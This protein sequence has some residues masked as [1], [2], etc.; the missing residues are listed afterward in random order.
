MHNQLL[1]YDFTKVRDRRTAY[2]Q[3]LGKLKT[4]RSTW[5]DHW[6]DISRHLLPR[7]GRY[8]KTDRNKTS[9]SKYNKIYDNSATRAL[10]TLGAGMMAGASNPAR[11]WFRLQTSDPELND[12]Y[13]VRLWLD[14]VV[15]RMQR[16][17]ARSNTYR[18]LHKMYEELGAFGTSVSIVLFDFD[19]VIHHYP[20]ANG[21]YSLQQNAQGRIVAVYREYQQTVGEVVKEYGLT[22]IS[23]A[24]KQAWRAR[25]LEMPIN[26]MHMI[27]PRADQ[28]RNP[29]SR[30][31]TDM[32]WKSCHLEMSSEDN[33]ILRES[34]FKHFPVLAPR[35][36]VDGD[37]VYGTGPGME[38]LGDIRQL[39]QE[40]LRKGQAI[41]YMVRPPLQ[42]PTRMKAQEHELFPGGMSYADPGTTLPFDQV[43]QHGGVRT[44]F[45]VK[46][47]IGAL[48]EDIKDCRSRI[49]SSFYADL[50]LMIQMADKNGMTA[51][52][53][54]ER[55][56][57]K[58]LALGPVL[59]RL[60]NELLNP[61]IDITFQH[62]ADAGLIPEAP[63]E[64]QGMELT[65][66]FVSILAQAQRQVGSNAID[67]FMSNVAAVV[68]IKP[69]VLDKIDF[70][71]WVD[72]MADMLGIETK[73]IVSQENVE[74][75]RQARAQYEAAQAQ[76][77]AQQ[78]QAATMKDA[79]SV[80]TDESNVVADQLRAA[81]QEA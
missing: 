39:Q 15:R 3:R 18:T 57:E 7:S 13:N 30:R 38:S 34:G 58:L 78:Q 32:A 11:P 65:V 28:E 20:V 72:S 41:D 48:L 59:E 10:R 67:R 50:F 71:E 19:N 69:E 55:H 21:Q 47:D 64:V 22:N 54:A 51:T 31:A 75:L 53:I 8:T 76:L 1:A 44:A 73:M 81:P 25:N 33:K 40:Q 2:L 27:E 66:E 63:E 77:A 29:T 43:T 23:E 17:F 49:N 14:D 12:S 45:D 80:K 42:V 56:E 79:G 36:A 4:D 70:D 5:V 62:M 6:S 68:E 35:W 74:R 60:H 61:L 37:D 16:V 26:L 46:L 52:E 9:K 24:V